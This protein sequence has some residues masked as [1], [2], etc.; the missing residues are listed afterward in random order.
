[1]KAQ[2]CRELKGI[3]AAATSAMSA[4]KVP[5][6]A[7][8]ERAW[9]VVVEALQSPEFSADEKKKMYELDRLLK[10]EFLAVEGQEFCWS[11]V[12]WNDIIEAVFSA[13]NL[14]CDR[15]EPRA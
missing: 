9:R 15:R 14:L 6:W 13:N 11:A 1:M 12:A 5:D 10:W 8:I 4:K 2:L 7:V 3:A